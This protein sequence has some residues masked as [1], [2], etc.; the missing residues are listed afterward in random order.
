LCKIKLFYVPVS[1]GVKLATL[2]CVDSIFINN[3]VPK[4]FYATGTKKCH[5]HRLQLA[6]LA[7]VHVV[8]YNA[9]F[10]KSTVI[11]RQHR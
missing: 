3:N 7:L 4:M 6:N 2:I 10:Y 5:F 1:I 8:T 9:D 11:I